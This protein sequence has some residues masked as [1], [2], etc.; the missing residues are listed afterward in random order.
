[1]LNY[2][3]C[4]VQS[5]DVEVHP[6]NLLVTNDIKVCCESALKIPGEG[7]SAFHQSGGQGG[8]HMTSV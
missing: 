6:V 4:S 7:K 8:K 2:D 1:M 3:F 5:K